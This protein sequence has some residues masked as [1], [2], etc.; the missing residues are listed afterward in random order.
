M[1]S[2]EKLKNRGEKIMNVTF[3]WRA[4]VQPS[5]RHFLEKRVRATLKEFFKHC[6][7]HPLDD[8]RLIAFKA[9]P[10]GDAQRL[11]KT[12]SLHPDFGRNPAGVPCIVHVEGTQG[13]TCLMGVD[14]VGDEMLVELLNN[15]P[16]LRKQK[17]VQS[18]NN[19]V[20]EDSA[21]V[22]QIGLQT[23]TVLYQVEAMS[24]EKPPI[25]TEVV[26][27]GRNLID[28]ELTATGL[29]Q[30]DLE[31]LRAFYFELV[32]GHFEGATTGNFFLTNAVISALAGPAFNIRRY[33]GAFGNFYASRI[34]TFADSVSVE[35]NPG[36]NFLVLK[37]LKFIEGTR[38][39]K[40]A[41]AHPHR[42]NVPAIP[43]P[44][45]A[46]IGLHESE[47]APS[48]GLDDLPVDVIMTGDILSQ[49]V[50]D[51]THSSFDFVAYAAL[52][53]KRRVERLKELHALLEVREILQGEVIKLR[54]K[55][56]GLEKELTVS[57]EAV[58]LAEIKVKEVEIPPEI[59]Q[60]ILREKARLDEEEKKLMDRRK[61]LDSFLSSYPQQST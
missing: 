32:D 9:G 55:L 43:A 48:V 12:V 31:C 33:K 30:H 34:R 22:F 19:G 16:Y 3:N 24:E 56:E 42:L 10:G 53:E 21:P 49:M 20:H 7:Q 58:S 27:E 44:G 36:W 57:D 6:S 59:M 1:V 52:L 26:S 39:P 38:I 51:N 29:A 35:D 50:K 15:G 8:V 41:F 60:E 18:K 45:T 13:L 37:V 23:A 14:E 11:I 17:V 61:L 25:T 2:G 28:K 40:M 47:K 5:S 46:Q 54:E 4:T